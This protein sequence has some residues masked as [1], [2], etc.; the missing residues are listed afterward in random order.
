MRCRTFGVLVFLA[1]FWVVSPASAAGIDQEYRKPADKK[2]WGELLLDFVG[3]SG[4]GRSYAL[5]VGISKFDDYPSLPTANDPLRM[6][7][8]LVN[9]A[10]FDYVHVLTDEKATKARIEELMVDVLPGMIHNN[11][12][13]LFYWSGHGTQRPNDFGGQLGYLPLSSSPIGRYATMIS[14]ADIQRWDDV[15]HAKQA[16]FL[17]D[18]CFSGLAGTAAKSE[19]RELQIDQLDKPAHHLVSAGTADE[20]TIAGDRWGGSIFTDAILR[21]VRGEADAETSYPKDGVVSLSE[22]I[23]YV[24]TRVAFEAPAAG[25]KRPIT[26]QPYNLRSN[27]GE[28]FFL[29]DDRKL[30]TL[31]SAGAQYQGHFENGMP[32]VA[33]GRTPPPP[34]CDHEADRIFWE[35]IKNE[36]AAG[37]FEAYLKRV[38][39]GELCG[40]FADIARLKLG[41]PVAALPSVTEPAR[42]GESAPVEPTPAAVEAALNLGP[43]D[44][45]AF[46]HALTA[47]GF[48][49]R[50]VD[51]AFGANTRGA[52]A[53]WQRSRDHDQTGYLTS[54][55]YQQVLAEPPPKPAVVLEPETPRHQ[56]VLA[57]PPPKL[58]VV[59]E[60]ET[61]RRAPDPIVPVDQGKRVALVI[62]NS[63]Y[64]NAEKLQNP[65]NDAR[66]IAEVLTRTGF[67]VT[68]GTDLDQPG[69]QQALRDFGLK[70]EEADVAVVYYAGHGVQVAGENYLLPVDATLER[71]RDLLYEALPLNL[72]MGE[73]AQSQKLGLVILD[74]C[75]DNPLAEHLR[76]ILGPIRSRLVGDG[77][78]RIDNLPSGT[79]VAFATRPGEVAVDGTGPHSPYTT[80]LLKHI[81]EPG[82]ELNLLFRKVRDTVLEETAYRQ[83]PRTYDA[84]GDEP[85]YFSQA[86]LLTRGQG[87]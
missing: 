70:A 47:L 37:Y 31:E 82:L 67:E 69:M 52:I 53:G 12:Q 34:T 5:V 18:A 13:F 44:R 45:K 85:F 71:E 74:A 6:R 40:L 15:I 80:A 87:N 65:G 86:A 57:E 25:W 32:V 36:T 49:T 50:G 16:L 24:K 83:E 46:Q 8:F 73:V 48:D 58:A 11:D 43:Q 2:T 60:P 9:E 29:T 64:K 3:H 22:L 23:G 66:S 30:A 62:G 84:L 20:E 72:V 68:L 7:D 21:A 38:E 77:L 51:G 41:S 78:A 14:M 54:E 81:E 76:R 63:A 28:F 56:E 33:K 42:R 17:L 61:Q 19:P 10:G 75:H 39:S 1:T 26:P 27:A 79:M 35:A 55:Q 4:V 59:R